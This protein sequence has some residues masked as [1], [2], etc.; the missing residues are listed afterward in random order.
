[1]LPAG[2]GRPGLSACPPPAPW[3]GGSEP[4]ERPR[5]PRGWAWRGE[6][7]QSLWGFGGAKGFFSRREKGRGENLVGG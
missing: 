3:T 1:M 5:S 4:A 2:C 6:F 7:I